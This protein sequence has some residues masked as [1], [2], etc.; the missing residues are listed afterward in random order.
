MIYNIYGIILRFFQQE[1]VKRLDA[2]LDTRDAHVAYQERV[3]KVL[4]TQGQVPVTI[5]QVVEAKDETTTPGTL[6]A[7]LL[8]LAEDDVVG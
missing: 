1:R 6:G 7:H 8:P 3:H 5:E 2:Y 4:Q